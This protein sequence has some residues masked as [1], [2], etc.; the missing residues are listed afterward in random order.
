MT[1]KLLI[2]SLVFAFGFSSCSPK[3]FSEKWT[4]D[5]APLTFKARF[6][7]TQGNFDIVA[8]RSLSPKGV[9]RLYQLIK[10]DFYTDIAIFRVV[11]NFVVQFGIHTDSIVNKHWEK[12]KIP[13]EKVEHSNNSMTISFARGGIESR[14]TQI[15]I[16]LKNNHRLDEIDYSGVK[17]FPVVAKVV[18]GTET[19]HK[20]YADYGG[21]PANEQDSIYAKGN[22]YLKKNYPK[23]DYIVKAYIIK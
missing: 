5:K 19:I 20:F 17:G 14:T 22:A 6:E 16:N 11:P 23:L 8:I 7:T 2:I 4:R 9:D 21:D 3:I 13:D 10:N 12:H 18:N 1:K 15:F